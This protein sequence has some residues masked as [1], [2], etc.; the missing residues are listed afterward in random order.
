VPQRLP[1]RVMLLMRQ[2]QAIYYL[3]NFSKGFYDTLEMPLF[4]THKSKRM[5]HGRKA[6]VHE[7]CCAAGNSSADIISD[8]G[9]LQSN[10][11]GKIPEDGVCLSARSVAGNEACRAGNRGTCKAGEL[12]LQPVLASDEHL[13]KVRTHLAHG[14]TSFPG[15]PCSQYSRV[16]HLHEKWPVP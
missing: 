5:H 6:L 9:S 10:Q 11:I 15:L 2:L 12:C 4:K 13:F 3:Y 7:T 1:H 14:A 16:M 8:L